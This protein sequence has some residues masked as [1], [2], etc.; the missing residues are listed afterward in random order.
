MHSEA[1][2]FDSAFDGGEFSNAAHGEM[3]ASEQE[4]IATRY[5]FDSARALYEAIKQR[6]SGKWMYFHFAPLLSELGE[7]AYEHDAAYGRKGNA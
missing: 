1:M 5:G 3:E 2:H 6:V 7:D 4:A